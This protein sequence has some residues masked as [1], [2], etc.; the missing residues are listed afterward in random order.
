MRNAWKFSREKD[1]AVIGFRVE[2]RNGERVYA[3]SDNG[4]GFE[5]DHAKTCSRHSSGC[6]SARFEGTGIGL[7]TVQRIVRRHGGRIWAEASPE[8][9]ATS[10]L[11]AGDGES[12]R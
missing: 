12:G 1:E 5:M 11:H 9:G 4:A 10:L 2:E 3:V 8:T 7:A 6:T